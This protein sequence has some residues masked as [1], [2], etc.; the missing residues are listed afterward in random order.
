MATPITENIAH[1]IEGAINLIT[2]ANGFEQD[3]VAQ[4][5]KRVD[6]SDVMPEN[7]K[8]LIVQCEEEK[9]DK[10]AVGC[11]EW[12]QIFA[13]VAFVIESDTGQN[14]EIRTSKVRDDIRKKLME[15]PTRTGY[16]ID[17]ILRAATPFDDGEGFTG[18]EIEIA[19]HYRTQYADPYTAA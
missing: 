10:V 16:A 1:D 5:H 19:C 6:F 7:G 4:R 2:V 13:L 14:I 17:T 8:V 3:L 15:D 12:L 18:I 9:P 11:Q